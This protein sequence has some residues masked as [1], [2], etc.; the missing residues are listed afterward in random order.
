MSWLQD[1]ISGSHGVKVIIDN[2][3]AVLAKLDRIKAQKD[4]QIIADFDM[5]MTAFMVD[6][7]RGK[8]SHRAVEDSPL[9]SDDYRSQ[10]KALFNHYYPIEISTTMP[11]EEKLKHME[12]WW[13][14]AH[15]LMMAQGVKQEHL[16]EVVKT[17]LLALRKGATSLIHLAK[18]HHIPLHIFS[19]GIYDIIHAF[20]KY[21]RLDHP[22]M[23]VVSNMMEFDAVTG[24]VV[25]FKGN[26]IHSFNKNGTVLRGSP[27]WA[28]VAGRRSIILLGDSITDVNMAVGLEVDTVLSVAFLNDRIEE[29][30][31]EFRAKFDVVLL[32]DAPMD[33]VIDVVNRCL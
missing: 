10:S 29:R 7:Q 11:A 30:L 23:H 20:F 25:G 3:A 15:D 28:H 14:K 17:P 33:F 19:A 1:W 5:T 6:G 4:L 13:G 31:P 8:S 2:P 9:F 12:E 27:G 18:E 24:K 32:D 22:G 16:C 26:L 21:L